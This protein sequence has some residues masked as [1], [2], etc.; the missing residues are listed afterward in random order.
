MQPLPQ[1]GETLLRSTPVVD[2][3]HRRPPRRGDRIRREFIYQFLERAHLATMDRSNECRHVTQDRPI[4]TQRILP[5]VPL[6]LEG[7]TRNLIARFGDYVQSFGS[8]PAFNDEQLGSHLE[9]LAL[10]SQLGSAATAANSSEFAKALR[11]TLELWHM[12]TRGAKLV[13]LSAFEASLQ[14]CAADIASFEND[15]LE[16]EG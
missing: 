5:S 4:Q 12:N 14:H 7:R 10:R 13:S 8:A 15:H 1:V 3:R 6:S 2:K 16:A 9:T 11:H